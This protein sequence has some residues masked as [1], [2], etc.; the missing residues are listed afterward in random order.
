MLEL[1]RL[2]NLPIAL[3]RDA[4]PIVM[5]QVFHKLAFKYTFRLDAEGIRTYL[6]PHQL[7]VAV[8]GGAEALIHSARD[9][10]AQNKGG[11]DMILLQKDL[12]NAFNTVLPSVFLEECRQYAPASSRLAVWCYGS[13]SHLV[14]EGSTY[15]SARGQ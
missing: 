11:E 4:R 3:D 6:L 13:A 8:A 7:A 12:S 10:I 1:E 5:Q 2:I 9:W 14:Y 15:A